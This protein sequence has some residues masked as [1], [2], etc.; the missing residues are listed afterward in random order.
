MTSKNGDAMF[1]EDLINSFSDVLDS[2]GKLYET[3]GEYMR[4]V[5]LKFVLKK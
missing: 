3:D 4:S 5:E 1:L 2:N